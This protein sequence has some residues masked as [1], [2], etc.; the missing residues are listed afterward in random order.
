MDDMTGAG[1][2]RAKAP[3]YVS[4]RTLR[5]FV[6]DLHVRGVPEQVRREDLQHYGSATVVTQL[7]AALRFMGLIDD[8]D[9]PT[10]A[11]RKQVD[12]YDTPDWRSVLRDDIRR[13]FPPIM[14]LDLAHATREQLDAAFREYPGSSEAVRRKCVQF[15]L[16]AARDAQFPLSAEL[17]DEAPRRRSASRG[18]TQGS[19]ADTLPLGSSPASPAAHP[20]PQTPTAVA[21]G[22]VQVPASRYR[23]A[24]DALSGVWDPDDMPEEVDAAIVTVLR[25][26]R[27]KESEAK[28]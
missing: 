18:T 14:R 22:Q 6:Q 7:I 25:H 15:F 2:G 12:A 3:P 11:L 28:A 1:G 9:R 23:A 8:D 5:T 10:P 20:L 21:P 19:G 26:L 13:A 4:Y 17:S 24:F 16:A 27:K